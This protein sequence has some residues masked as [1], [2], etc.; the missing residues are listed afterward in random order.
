MKKYLFPILILT[1]AIGS[2]LFKKYNFNNIPT[3]AQNTGYEQRVSLSID[4]GNQ[5]IKNYDLIIKA[6][7]T[8][9]SIL[10]NTTEKEKINLETK[11]YDFGVFVKKIGT[12]E[13][14]A[15]K[16]WIYYVNGESGQIAADKNFVK[17]N[18]KILWKFEAPKL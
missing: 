6:E 7:D 2:F 15:K 14:T 11:Q 4:F 3:P 12:F 1:L 10:K 16:S 17:N 5:D 18:D 8:A 9:Y 13:S